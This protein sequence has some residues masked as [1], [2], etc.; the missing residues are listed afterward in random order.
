MTSAVVSGG[1]AI[2]Q[3][4][5]P[6]VYHNAGAVAVVQRDSDRITVHQSA[7]L[8]VRSYAGPQGIQGI[9]GATGAA[10]PNLVGSTTATD[11]TGILKGNGA[12]VAVAEAGTDYVATETDPLAI[13]KD[14][15]TALAAMIPF[16]SGLSTEIVRM[17]D[18]AD[19]YGSYTILQPGGYFHDFWGPLSGIAL[20]SILGDGILLQA[21]ANILLDCPAGKIGITNETPGLLKLTAGHMLGTAAAGTDYLAPAGDGSSLTGVVH[22]EADP[23]FAAWVA[24]VNRFQMFTYFT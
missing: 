22:T 10:G 11:L 8:V 2:V 20:R 19:D 16:V 21:A 14:G 3:D 5:A 9:T 4:Q 23:V 7:P 24:S 17:L 15:S 18:G 12:T 1:V 6:R 13:H